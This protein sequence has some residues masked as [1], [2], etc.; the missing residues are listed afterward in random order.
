MEEAPQM[1]GVLVSGVTHTKDEAKITILWVP[2]QPGIAAKIFSRLADE[3][4]NIDVIV[5]DISEEGTTNISFTIPERDLPKA[6]RVVE[7]LVAEIGAKGFQ[8]DDR[9][10]KVSVVGV[11]MR[12][13]SGVA[14][15]MFQA[16]YE[17]GINILMISTSEIKISC[18]VKEDRVEEA[19]RAIHER[20]KLSNLT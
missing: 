13:H 2:D 15:A 16:L 19:V 12:S 4:L 3:D 8:A 20:F 7:A 9:I 6:K 1:E 10:G 5:Q 11:G 14:A 18:I 17:K